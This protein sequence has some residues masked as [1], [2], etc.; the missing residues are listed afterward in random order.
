MTFELVIEK[1]ERQERENERE[2]TA[3]DKKQIEYKVLRDER[4]MV[5]R[6]SRILYRR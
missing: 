3:A 2:P 1:K 6:M 5:K 4:L